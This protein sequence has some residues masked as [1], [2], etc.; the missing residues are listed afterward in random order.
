[1]RR[2]LILRLLVALA[3]TRFATADEFEAFAVPKMTEITHD[4]APFEYIDVGPKIPNYT[5]GAK[6]G[7]QGEPKTTMQLPLSVEESMKHYSLPEE[8]HCDCMRMNEIS[9]PSRS[10]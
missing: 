6:W 10:P 7:V 1:M 8:W 4:V 5:P 9:K 2:F 3:I